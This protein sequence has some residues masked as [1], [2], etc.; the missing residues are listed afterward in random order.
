MTPQTQTQAVI[1][2][3]AK[4][5]RPLLPR[6]L[7]SL[8]GIKG[9]PSSITVVLWKLARQGTV[10]KI[11]PKGGPNVRWTLAGKYKEPALLRFFASSLGEYEDLVL[12]SAR[13]IEELE[14][15]LETLQRENIRLRA[16]LRSLGRAGGKKP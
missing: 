5:K 16:Q 10:H 11:G 12:R 2:T 14:E 7:I 8:G 15:I 1:Q 3:L 9:S 4:A 13:R 6:E